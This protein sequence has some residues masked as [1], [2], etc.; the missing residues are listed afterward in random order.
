MNGEQG[1]KILYVTTV[2]G[3]M[4]AFLISHIKMLIDS[5]HNVDVAFNID[6]EISPIFQTI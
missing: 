5:G 6:H 3:T 1:M 2:S 4:N